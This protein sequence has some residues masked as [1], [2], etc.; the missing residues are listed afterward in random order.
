MRVRIGGD[1]PLEKPL[2][3]GDRCEIVQLEK[4][5]HPQPPVTGVLCDYIEEFV[6]D[7]LFCKQ[8]YK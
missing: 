6:F 2:H 1:S 8:L 4:N 5:C 7:I 3:L